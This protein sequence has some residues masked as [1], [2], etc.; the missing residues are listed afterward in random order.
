M[1]ENSEGWSNQFGI[2]DITDL[3]NIIQLAVIPCEGYAHN[4]WLNDGGD[5]LVT[6]EETENMTIKIWDKSS[7]D[8]LNGGDYKVILIEMSATW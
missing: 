1:C 5:V 4:A 8:N 6:T 3:N 2:Y 7:L